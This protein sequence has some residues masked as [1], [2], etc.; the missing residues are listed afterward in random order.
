MS[1]FRNLIE[2]ILQEAKQV[3]LLY[4]NTPALTEILKSNCLKSHEA[5]GISFDN[6]ENWFNDFGWKSNSFY[7]LI[8]D[9]DK[10]SENY[11]IIP[12]TDTKYEIKVIPSHQNPKRIED[13]LN[14]LIIDFSKKYNIPAKALDNLYDDAAYTHQPEDPSNI[15]NTANDQV[16][17]VINTFIKKYKL[18]I[19]YNKALDTKLWKLSSNSESNIIKPILNNNYS[20]IEYDFYT[21]LYYMKLVERVIECDQAPY[22]ELADPYI[23]KDLNKYLR[24]LIVRYP[25]DTENINEI[26]YINQN[27]KAFKNMYPNIP[28]YLR[29]EY[30]NKA[31]LTKKEIDALPEQK[32]FNYAPKGHNIDLK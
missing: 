5:N 22:T 11:K 16:A 12:V 30:N 23:L 1:K 32:S 6:E 7:T 14:E 3:G 19:N 20:E 21:I 13:K 27:I 29:D 17:D 31:I 8:L 9:G 25:N 15:Y 10:L 18:P 28:V 26:S 24:G 2:R 4:H